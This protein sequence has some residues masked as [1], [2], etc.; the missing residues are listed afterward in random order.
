MHHKPSKQVIPTDDDDEL[1]NPMNANPIAT[2]PWSTLVTLM[3]QAMSPGL[4]RESSPERPVA[5]R[6][7]RAHPGFLDRLDHWFWEQ[8]QRNDEEWL[9]QAQDVADL[10]VRIHALERSNTSC[11]Y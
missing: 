7:P 6:Q 2:D 11:Y 8:R 4:P 9:A 1:E 5:E 10:E 3:A